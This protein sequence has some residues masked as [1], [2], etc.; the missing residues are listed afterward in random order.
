MQIFLSW[1]L[2]A[3]RDGAMSIYHFAK[4]MDGAN[5]WAFRSQSFAAKID[6]G[7]LC[8]AFKLLRT[9]FA[10]FEAVRHAVAHA[11]DVTKNPKW[12]S[13]HTLKGPFKNPAI[14]LDDTSTVTIKNTILNDVFMS[15]FNNELQEYEVS[16]KTLNSLN[17]IKNTFYE[18]FPAA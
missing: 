3:A 7:R 13:E 12:L 11:A 1:R 18:A 6:K 10:K 2:I 4:A 14:I 9:Y 16:I 15:T 17:E 5:T 8:D